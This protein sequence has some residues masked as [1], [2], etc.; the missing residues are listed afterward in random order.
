LPAH[1]AATLAFYFTQ[2]QPERVVRLDQEGCPAFVQGFRIPLYN[3]VGS[4]MSIL[5]G[6]VPPSQA[7]FRQIG[8][9]VSIDRG[10]FEV[11]VLVWRDAL[12][13]FTDTTRQEDSLGRHMMSRRREYSLGADFLRQITPPTLYL[14]GEHDPFGGIELGQ[15]C[16]AAQ[17]NVTL[18]SF[19]ASG[20]LP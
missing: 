15:R 19:P 14:W 13:K 20:H 8:H 6:Y 11:E 12:L 5:F 7:A 10:R 1:W 16:A 18:K 2:V 17:P 9:T 3:I 4:V